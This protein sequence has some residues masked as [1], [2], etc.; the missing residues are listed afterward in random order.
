MHSRV[1]IKTEHTENKDEEIVEMRLTIDTISTMTGIYTHM[2]VQDIQKAI[3][4]DK[5]SQ[6]LKEYIIRG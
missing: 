6:E 5:H 3:K 4:N 2:P 1:A